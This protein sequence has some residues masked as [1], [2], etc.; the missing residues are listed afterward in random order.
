M[1]HQPALV[2]AINEREQELNSINRR[3]ITGQAD[4]VSA[5]VNRM[6]EFVTER[7]G[8]IRQ[9]LC[10]DV[11]RAKAE[12]AKHVTRV[13]MIP[14]I[15]GK[16]GHYVAAGEWNLLGGFAENMDASADMRVRLVAGA[17][18]VPNALFIPFRIELAR[19]A[20]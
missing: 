6:R 7:L 20:A 10:A 13:Q 14:Q 12:L 15:I 1:I 9:L 2:E 19:S 16:K 18:N 17:C 3:L 4:S 11:Q 8:D 5:Q